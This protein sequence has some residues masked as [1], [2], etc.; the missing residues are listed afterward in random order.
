MKIVKDLLLLFGFCVPLASVV[1]TL[2]ASDPKSST[3]GEVESA[4]IKH[5]RDA[6]QWCLTTYADNLTDGD[7][8]SIVRNRD[9]KGNVKAKVS[10]VAQVIVDKKGAKKLKK[11]AS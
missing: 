1:R 9:A 8:I 2:E 3:V 7:I 10:Y 4:D 5:G 11:I 6:A